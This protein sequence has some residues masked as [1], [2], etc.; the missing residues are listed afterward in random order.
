VSAAVVV[1]SEEYVRKAWAM[2]ELALLLERHKRGSEAKL[3]PVFYH[4]M[5]TERVLLEAAGRRAQAGQL[6]ATGHL[7]RAATLHQW[8]NDLEALTGI[9]GTR[10]D[11]VRRLHEHAASWARAGRVVCVM[12]CS[13]MNMAVETRQCAC[14]FKELCIEPPSLQPARV[15]RGVLQSRGI[16]GMTHH[17]ECAQACSGLL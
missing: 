12:M 11:Q 5:T 9:T 16:P 14:L 13:V 6:E 2:E 8:A 17:P 10:T 1:L 4:P 7:E 3:L 15:S